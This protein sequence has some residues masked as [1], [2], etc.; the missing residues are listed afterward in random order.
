[1]K[2][3]DYVRRY[4]DK[5][6]DATNQGAARALVKKHPGMWPN[7]EAATTCVRRAR[8]RQGILSRSA[9]KAHREPSTHTSNAWAAPETHAKGKPVV[10]VSGTAHWLL[11]SDIHAPYH[12]KEALELAVNHGISEGCDSLY[13]N[14]DTMDFHRLSRFEQDEE[15]RSTEQEITCGRELVETLGKRFGRKVY[16]IGNHDNRWRIY[17]NARCPEF[18][19][20]PGMALSGNLGLADHGYQVLAS[21]QVGMLGKLPV[22]HGHELPKGL[23]NS[24]NPARGLFL[25]L[26]ET[27]ICGHFH[28][29]ST[30]NEDTGLEKN[31]VVC[32]STGC[33][34]DLWP[35]Y[36]VVNKWSH[37]WATVKV[38]A[39]GHFQVRNWRITKGEVTQI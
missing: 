12:N 10:D 34:C 3:I 7:V 36:A 16:K 5:Y 27:A 17:L 1:M 21:P 2:P 6:P 35:E 33:L 32:W 29:P 24:V 37:G 9:T 22:F 30:H 15:A 23:T 25:R 8:G 14:G 11:L 13:L 20:M 31:T 39:A 28:Q 4:L 38:D 26:R 19:R 18:S